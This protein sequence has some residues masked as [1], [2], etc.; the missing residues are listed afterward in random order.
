MPLK[1]LKTSDDFWNT[2]DDFG[3]TS[4]DFWMLSE[5]FW[6]LLMTSDDCLSILFES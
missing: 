5:D 6:R 2:F 4:E 3:S 1:N